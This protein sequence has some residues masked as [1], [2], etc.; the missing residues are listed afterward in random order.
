VRSCLN[1][2][3]SESESLENELQK[4]KIVGKKAS[5]A[6]QVRGPRAPYIIRFCVSPVSARIIG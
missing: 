4:S 3:L 1:F 2:C 5:T 6:S